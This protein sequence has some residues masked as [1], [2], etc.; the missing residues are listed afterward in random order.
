MN[1]LLPRP[2]VH[3]VLAFALA[4]AG[5]M[6]AT[7]ATANEGAEFLRFEGLTRSSS[8]AAIEAWSVDVSTKPL[9]Q[10]EPVLVVDLFDGARH[11]IFGYEVEERGPGDLVWRGRFQDGGQAVLTV[12]NG[13]VV[14][15]LF[16]PDGTYELTTSQAGQILQK[17]DSESFA[18]CAHEDLH[19]EP[20][21][22]T[23]ENLGGLPVP[24][25]STRATR[26]SFVIDVMSVYTAAAR[27]GAGGTAQIQ[28]TA[29]SAIDVSNTAF[30]NSQTSAQF[31]LV[32]TAEVSYSETGNIQTDRNWLQGNSTV[33]S[34]RDQFD[35]DL[36]GMLVE[37]GGGF[38]GIAFLMG[39][40]DPAAF[41]PFGYQVTARTCAVGNLS[42]PHEHGHNM[43][44][45][46]NPQ[47]GA[48]SSQATYVWSY[49]HYVNGNYRT[50]MSYSNPCSQGCTRQPYFSNPDVVFQGAA[51]GINNQRDNSRTIDLIAPFTAA[52]RS[53]GGGTPGN[54]NGT[55]CIDW[56]N[57]ATVS[58]SNQDSSGNVQVQDG[59]DTLYLE[60]NTWRRTTQTFNVTADTTIEFD[61]RSTSQGEIHGIGF[62]EDDTLT[63]DVRIFQL[64]GTQNWGGANHDFDNYSGSGTTSYSIPVGQYYTGGSMR[65]V[66]VNDNDAGSNNTSYFTNVRVF[67]DTGG[68]GSCAVDDD[69]ESGAAGWSNSGASTCSTG[70]F[71]LG[72]PTLQTNSGVT[73]QVGG[74]HSSPGTNA[75]YTA[76]NTSAGNADVDNGVCI[77]DS[78][79]WNVSEASTLSI[80]Y[81]H[82][83]RDTGDDGAGDFFRISVSTDD[84][85][86]YT[87]LVSIGDT[88]TN[89]GWTQAT[90]SIAAGAEVKIMVEVSDGTA[91]GDLVEGGIDDLSICP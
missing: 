41:S 76:S 29:Q 52:Y 42:Y 80:W 35:A 27:N 7:A 74:D 37:N 36:V 12:K 86:N 65:L 22:R 63:N 32:H 34:L 19:E 38:C 84:G 57:T 58:Y 30:T 55:N 66:L 43:G 4:I 8:D 67:E 56:D 73:T 82:G 18:P 45:Q 61:F 23:L 78:P 44:L 31:N 85:L 3:L 24:D 64:H 40:E 2:S 6:L 15:L 26:G 77:L 50:V 25:M 17:L 83:Q 39:N 53:G 51:T 75:I 28:A 68:G 20:R 16:A 90:R 91:A 89:A 21:P 72:A 60:D 54:C 1:R 79:T 47:N 71:I 88:R 11:E 5:S 10:G 87:N 70:A 14:G 62:D 69:F 48:P 33:N 46:H 9:E 59:G 49:G 13:F 81:F